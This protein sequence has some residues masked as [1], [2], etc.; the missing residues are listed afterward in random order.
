MAESSEFVDEMRDALKVNGS[1][2]NTK[3]NIVKFV[4]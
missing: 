4:D 1:E 3:E 2:R